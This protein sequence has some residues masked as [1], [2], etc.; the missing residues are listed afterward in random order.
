[1][2]RLGI[3]VFYDQF[4]IVDKYVEVLL[5]GILSELN[6]LYIIING[7]ITNESEQC[8]RK[9]SDNIFFRE[10]VGYDGGAYKDAFLEFLTDEN[11]EIWDEVVLFNDT[12]YGPIFPW[13]NVFD[14]MNAEKIDFW[15]LTRH[16][17]AR[18][19]LTSGIEL[20]SHIQGYFLV[21]RKSLVMSEAFWMFWRLLEYPKSYREAVENFEIKF[22]TYFQEKG[23]VN[24]TYMEVGDNRVEVEYGKDPYYHKAYD[25]LTNLH[26]PV[27]KRKVFSLVNFKE[28]QKILDYITKETDYDKNLIYNH[29]LRLCKENRI[30]AFNPLQLE[31]FYYSHNRIFIYGHG[32]YGKNIE[33]YLN[34]KGWKHDGFIV[35][36]KGE[37]K[38]AV[39]VYKDMRFEADDGIILA[40]GKDA[41]DEVY[42]V[43]QAQ[44]STHQLFSPKF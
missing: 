33:A 25:L 11:W 3:F 2:R 24:E 16:P 42:P 1:M 5:S 15:G 22:S 38:E 34:Y 21:C 43:I 23:F 28:V 29:L 7:N 12:F 9:Y 30:G 32:I 39:F 41:F 37:D 14:R 36:E 6:K 8:L 35:S 18:R 27:V 31:K 40:L 4:G 44:V 10:N 13:K 26:F 20:P 19:R 17:G